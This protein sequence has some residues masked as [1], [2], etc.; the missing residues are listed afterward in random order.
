MSY[1]RKSSPNCFG[2]DRGLPGWPVIARIRPQGTFGP[3]RHRDVR[4]PVNAPPPDAPETLRCG[5][6]RWWAAAIAGILLFAGVWAA[7][8]QLPRQ[9]IFS[10]PIDSAPPSPAVEVRRALPI[11]EVRRALPRALRA[12][13]VNSTQVPVPTTGWQSIRMPNG[14]IVDAHYEGELSSS[15]QLPLRGNYPGETYSTDRGNTWWIWTQP[16]GTNV[17]SWVDP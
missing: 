17:A 3:R 6:A 12:L 16:A 15:A 5:T 2:P 10:P 8:D 4:G 7:I 1:H 13:P 14:S 9:V 11:V